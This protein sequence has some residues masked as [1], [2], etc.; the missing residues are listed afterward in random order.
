MN[1]ELQR[2]IVFR[3]QR[4]STPK[5]YWHGTHCACAPS[6]TLER[7][8]P[9]FRLAGLTR[10]ANITGLDRIGIPTTLAIRP[11][12]PTLTVSSGKGFTSDAAYVS[13]AME[14]LELFHAEGPAVPYFRCPYSQLDLHGEPLPLDQLA[15]TKYSLFTVD[16]PFD[17]SLGWDIGSQRECPVPLASVDMVRGPRGTTALGAFQLTSNGLA[18]GNTFLE[19]VTAGL[20]EVIERDA[21]TCND[22]AWEK[23]KRAP[24]RVQLETLR[25]PLVVELIATLDAAG[26]SVVLLD[27]TVDTAVPVFMAFVCDR[28]MPR[29]GIYKGYGA[30]LDPEIAM[31]RAITEAIQ[32]RLI[33]IAG[34]RD[35]A[36][37]HHHTRVRRNSGAES[38]ARLQA[39]EAT[40][41][42][43]DYRSMATPSFE[44]DLH[45][46]LAKLRNAGLPR[47]IVF[48]LSRTPFP[49]AVV[50]V[51]VPGAEGYLFDMY[52]PG[53]RARRFVQ[54]QTLQ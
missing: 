34:S 48:D 6:E 45:L 36:F 12:S 38:I 20:Y 29:I 52:A 16:W 26:I 17:W 18:S 33:F 9:F 5:T 32:S 15:L 4:H 10:V 30:H 1:P 46:L 22:L 21:V 7:I 8:R 49:V 43:H 35:D 3:G 25:L 50:K 39:I 54:Q 11:N 37:R 14:A 51:L 47:V 24:P 40:I 19:A 42:G 44:G 23:S 2:P 53:K 41:D 31:I 28:H 13:G 27:C